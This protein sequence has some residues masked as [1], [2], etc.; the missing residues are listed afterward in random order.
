MGP[1]LN[2]PLKKRNLIKNINFCTLLRTFERTKNEY[3]ESGNHILSK[4]KDE[5]LL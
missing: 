2:N 5:I 1:K 3:Y 4:S